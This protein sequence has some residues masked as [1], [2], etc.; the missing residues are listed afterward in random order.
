[1]QDEW[2]TQAARDFARRHVF[3]CEL[4]EK[5]L[6]IPVIWMEDAI[7]HTEE[8]PWCDDK[9]CPCHYDQKQ[10]GTTIDQ[11]YTDGLITID[12]GNALYRG[13]NI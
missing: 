4:Q 10:Y 5:G 6:P 7:V 9:L 2:I 11:P 3:E 1:M 13:R 12:E 8:R